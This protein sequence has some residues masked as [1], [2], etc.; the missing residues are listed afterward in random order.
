[1][2]TPFLNTEAFLAEAIE[3]VLAQ[4]FVNWEYILVDDGSGPAATA[5][6]KRYAARYPDKIR[7]VEHAGHLNRGISATRNAGVQ[8]AH[9]EYIAFLDSDDIWM[10]NKLTD[11]VGLLDRY[12]DVGMVCGTTIVWNSWS[13]GPDRIMPTGERQD[14][15]IYPPDS[16][17]TLYPLG[18]ARAPSFSDVVFRADLVRRLGGFEEQFTGVYDDQVLLL[19]VYLNTPVYFSSV[20]S[21]KYRQHPT[22]CSAT[23]RQEGKENKGTLF[24]LEWL[25]QYL[26]TIPKVDSRVSA[27]LNRA[28]WPYRNPRINKFLSASMSVRNTVRRKLKVRTRLRSI[29]HRVRPRNPKPIILMYHRIADPAIDPW[30]LSVSQAHF[31][32]QLRVLHRNRQPFQLAEFIG[33]FSSGSLPANAVALTFDDGYVDNLVAGKPLLAAEEIPASVFLATGYIG[34]SD[35]FWWDEL[36]AFILLLGNPQKYEMLARDHSMH[37]DFSTS[38]TG[39]GNGAMAV[40]SPKNRHAALWTIWQALRQLEDEERRSIMAKL[41]SVFTLS[42]SQRASLGRAMTRD[43]VRSITS[44]GLVAVG[45]HTITHPMLTSLG[46]VACRREITESMLACE[47]LTGAKI[48]TFS[49]PF[50]DYDAKVREAV[51]AAGFMAACSMQSGPVIGT[52]DVLALPRIHVRNI[53]GDAFERALHYASVGD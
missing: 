4:T 9:G 12:R 18:E 47:E 19:K 32:E 10:P 11:H 43:E 26:T 49:Y 31:K 29:I 24:F 39:D 30:G 52:S 35:A 41:R 44:D 8:H 14:V 7:Y 20:I 6:A 37:F 13:G 51:K 42:M 28:L 27:S 53:D 16:A 21:N 48:S 17:V 46:S 15:L 23:A 22:S 5:I 38:P 40:D 36:A 50:G 34:Q 45:A 3:S 33:R 2:I 1:V 25:E